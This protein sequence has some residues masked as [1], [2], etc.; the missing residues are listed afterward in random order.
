MASNG[1]GWRLRI[2]HVTGFTYGGTAYASYNEA[3]MTPLTVPGQ[4]TLFSQVECTPGATTWRYRDYWGT[5]VTVFDLQRAHQ[6]LKVTASSL[7]ETADAEPSSSEPLSWDRLHNESTVDT[8]LEYLT[9]TALTAVDSSLRDT[10]AALVSDSPADTAH[11]IAEWVRANV[12]Y[13]PGSTGVR[14][15]AQEAWALRK[16]VCQDIAQLTAG[17]LRRVGIPAR[18]VSGYL[19]PRSA[20]S[21][22]DTVAG[23]SHA[24]V[25]WYTGEW[26]GF[27]P[28]NG[29]RI[30]KRHVIVARGRD[31]ADVTPLKGV[32]HG[33]P[34][35]D[36]GVTVEITRLA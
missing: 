16:G 18:Y 36:L 12:E 21:V 3:R 23:Q 13:Q 1:D 8:Y 14:T 17:M 32:Y 30:G 15:S 4:N 29:S 7:V 6:Q 11:A 22:G 5:A 27:D 34:A 20:A 24:W 26:S 9:P 28:T 33:A 2:K 25:E 19:Y 31:Y 10:A 35:S